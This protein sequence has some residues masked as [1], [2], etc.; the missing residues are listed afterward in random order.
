MAGKNFTC[1]ASGRLHHNTSLLDCVRA[2]RILTGYGLLESKRIVEDT[3]ERVLALRPDLTWPEVHR[4][5]GILQK[6][7]CIIGGF[8]YDIIKDLQ[9]LSQR[10]HDMGEVE[11]ANEISQ[12]IMTEKLR[13]T[14]V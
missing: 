1:N 4:Q 11:L 9:V 10:A 12:L 13:R 3:N 2:I 6:N 7:G 8:A 5:V 14:D